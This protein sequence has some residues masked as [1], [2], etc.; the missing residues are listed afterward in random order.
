MSLSPLRSLLGGAARRAGITRDLAIT[1]VLRAVQEEL[2]RMFGTK[3]AA[4]ADATA[5]QKDG[6][7]VVACRSP[8]VAQTLRLQE[9]QIIAHV[10]TI[11]TAIPV[12]RLFLVPR[13][14]DDLRAYVEALPPEPMSGSVAEE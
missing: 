4:F 11:A 13:S 2:T 7:I 6:S 14:R 1:L 5:V 3:Y 10:R 9:Q 12:T 8:A